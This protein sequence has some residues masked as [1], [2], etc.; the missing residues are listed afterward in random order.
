MTKPL[1]T[2]R[3]VETAKPKRNAKGELVRN[4]IPDGTGL[5]LYLVIEPTGAK[6]WYRRYRDSNGKPKRAKLGDAGTLTL[7][8]AR[9]A[10][11]SARLRSDRQGDNAP[12]PVVVAGGDRIEIAIAQF[13]DKHAYA[14]TRE[15][16]AWAAERMFN[17]LVL[18]R[19]KGRTIGSI[20]RRDVIELVEHV[21]TDRPYLAN[22]TLGVLHKF[23]AWLCAR[24]A[25]AANPASGV[26]RPHAEQPREHIVIDA[27][28]AALW[29][30]G[31]GDV[32]GQALRLMLLTGTRRNEAS[33]MEWDEIDDEIDPE[34]RLWIIPKERTKNGR[35]HVVPL[36]PQAWAIIDAM[37]RLAGC[38][39]VFTVDGRNPIIGWA[40]A[41]TRLSS[42]GGIDEA[43][44]RLHDLRRTAAS[45]MQR[46]GVPVPVVEKALNHISGTFRGIVSTYQQHD[47]RDEIAIALQKWADHVER[48]VGG[49]P[50]KVVK[51]R[52]R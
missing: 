49:K 51:L 52:R 22:R 31:E 12:V 41:K 6:S 36:S 44:W 34:A 14:K 47:Y 2:A 35:E 18:P 3:T 11:T 39:Y 10:A 29:R 17:R 46:L 25:L 50:A 19:W 9:H 4:E 48:L 8:A 28:V 23:F 21:A 1:L 45:G 32:F 43:G 16:T 13:L 26:E 7:A 38:P 20:T 15:S 40:K 37:P 5:G 27:D 30:A 33:R 24:D 42:K